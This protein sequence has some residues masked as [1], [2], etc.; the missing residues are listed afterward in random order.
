MVKSRA[1]FY[2]CAGLFLL[3]LAF[4]LGARAAGAQ[5]GALQDVAVLSGVVANGGTIPLP[6]YQDG[7]EALES[8]CRWTVSPEVIASPYAGTVFH[9]CSTEGRT[10]HVY[11]CTGGCGPGGDCTT[12]PPDCNR[13]AP[14][15]ANYLVVAVRSIGPTPAQQPTWGAVKSRYRGQAQPTPTDR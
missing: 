13:L 8:E 11:W 10:V 4:H 5:I 1:F 6:H 15:T 12:D 3:A 7:S 14:G 9:R 2:V